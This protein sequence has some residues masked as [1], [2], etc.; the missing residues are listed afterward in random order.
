LLALNPEPLID[1]CSSD[2]PRI[3][4]ST[5]RRT[6]ANQ[7]WRK[8]FFTFPVSVLQRFVSHV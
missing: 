3:F 6:S 1:V 8:R 5:G 4:S 2:I 7:Q